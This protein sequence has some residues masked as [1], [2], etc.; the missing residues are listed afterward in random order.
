M[1]TPKSPPP[2]PKGSSSAVPEIRSITDQILDEFFAGLVEDATL[3]PGVIA[4]LRLLA[5][6]GKL[7][8]SEEILRVLTED[9]GGGE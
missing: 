2:S 3:P 9:R 1:S 6:K 5:H 8:N 4:E 7:M